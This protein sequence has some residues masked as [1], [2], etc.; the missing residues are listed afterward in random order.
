MPTAA[1][2][3]D[4]QQNGATPRG[5]PSPPTPACTTAL[6]TEVTLLNNDPTTF[7][8]GYAPRNYGHHGL[9]EVTARYALQYSL[10]NATVE[11]AQMV[12]YDNVAAL[13]R[14]AGIIDAEAHPPSHWE[15]TALP[16]SKWPAPTLPL[17]TTAPASSLGRS[18]PS[19][20]PMAIPSAIISR[21]PSPSS[22]RASPISPQICCRT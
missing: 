20:P 4:P 14:D 13:A 11:L 12:G 5:T 21:T 1:I 22:I 8:G 16:P 6:F 9:G 19:A 3:G 7:E 10:N 18:P 2:V 15:P 17:P